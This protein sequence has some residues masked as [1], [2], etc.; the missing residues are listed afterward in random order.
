MGKTN[1]LEDRLNRHSKGQVSFT[2]SR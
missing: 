2:S 1:D